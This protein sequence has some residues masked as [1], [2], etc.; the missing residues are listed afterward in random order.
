MVCIQWYHLRDLV[1]QG[2]TWDKLTRLLLVTW[3]LGKK[4]SSS[5]HS[6]HCGQA[7]KT[8]SLLSGRTYKPWYSFSWT[9]FAWGSCCRVLVEVKSESFFCPA[10]KCDK[11]WCSHALWCSVSDAYLLLKIITSLICSIWTALSSCCF[12][13]VMTYAGHL[14]GIPYAFI[15]CS[16]N[17]FFSC[18]QIPLC[19]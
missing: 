14:S 7:A 19:L 8:I 10:V 3:V 11:W 1:L 6:V 16:N 2:S 12:K 5:D 18:V 15:I 13:W 17:T 9:S 4:G